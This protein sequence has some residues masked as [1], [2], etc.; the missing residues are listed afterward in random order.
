[1]KRHRFRIALILG[2]CAATLGGCA[3]VNEAFVAECDTFAN[4]TVLPD[5]ERY[6]ANDPT[7]SD[8]ERLDRL[9][10]VVEFRRA[11]ASAKGGQ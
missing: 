11:V 9:F 5:Y 7:L 8:Q 1:M 10:P 2:A 6:V 3:G 4:S